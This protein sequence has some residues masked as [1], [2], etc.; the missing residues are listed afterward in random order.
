[1]S[2]SKHP[3][4]PEDATPEEIEFIEYAVVNLYKSLERK[5]DMFLVAFC[6]DLGYKKSLAAEILGLSSA[7]V[8]IR[9]KRIQDRLKEIYAKNR[10][11]ESLE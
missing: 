9:L 2:L 11:V 3:I 10:A 8:T 7:S 4:L 1:M 5:E 6:Y